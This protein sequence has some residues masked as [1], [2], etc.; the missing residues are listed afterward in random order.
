[1]QLA[2]PPADTPSAPAP[3]LI[4]MSPGRLVAGLLFTFSVG[5]VGGYWLHQPPTP[6]D[7]A[8]TL[9]AIDAAQKE[10]DRILQQQ[11]QLL[12]CVPTS[13]S[14]LHQ[15]PPTSPTPPATR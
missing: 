4:R 12:N 2:S 7:D 8:A 11:R 10:T 1:M 5:F 13:E 6:R 14:S 9:A 15:P 3:R